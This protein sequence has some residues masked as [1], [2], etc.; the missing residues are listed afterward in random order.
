MGQGLGL[1]RILEVLIV[2]RSSSTYCCIYGLYAI[3]RYLP[4]TQILILE[5]EI[6][7]TLYLG[8][9]DPW[10]MIETYLTGTT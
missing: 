9:S 8:L 10:G 1:K 5:I 6:L 3:K 2:L 7:S 4:K